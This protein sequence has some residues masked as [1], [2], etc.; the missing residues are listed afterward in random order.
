MQPSKFV[1]YCQQA[2]EQEITAGRLVLDNKF[3]YEIHEKP[4]QDPAY[5]GIG[6]ATFLAC[7]E[8][9]SV[10]WGFERQYKQ[11]KLARPRN[12]QDFERLAYR[13]GRTEFKASKTT[14]FFLLRSLYGTYGFST[15]F[16]AVTEVTAEKH[17]WIKRARK[18]PK[19]HK[20][21][22]LDKAVDALVDY[23]CWCSQQ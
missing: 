3:S 15:D 19:I 17:D 22:G 11:P 5:I 23:L 14:G 20:N 13:I 10:Q 18:T 21:Q 16:S 7:D 9:M 1:R 12:S 8:R 2:M 4:G 6:T